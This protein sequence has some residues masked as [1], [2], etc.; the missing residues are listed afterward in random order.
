MNQT[1][2][3]E[4]KVKEVEVVSGF[5]LIQTEYKVKTPVFE[6]V[7]IQRP[8]FVDH[9]VKI[10]VGYDKVV[11][12]LALEISKAVLAI[13]QTSM[14]K[15]VKLLE[16]KISSLRNIKTEE[17]V[18]LKTKEVIVEKPVYKDVE[19]EVS[20]PV[21]VDKEVINPILKNVDVENAIIIDKAVTNA[22]ITDIRVTNAIIKD[23]EVERA[24]IREKVIEVI[25][26]N[27][28]DS[29]GNPIS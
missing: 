10:P 12:E 15:Q 16:D 19:I 26:K 9:E 29:A 11:N 14:D 4:G 23:V 1:N 20:R 6:E 18:I 24:V 21:Y 13:V 8:I 7:T 25:H 5:K 2:P 17:E 27:C 22:V 28:L 3:Q